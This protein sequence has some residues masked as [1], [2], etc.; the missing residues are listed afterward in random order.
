M[1]K[2][3][4]GPSRCA[5]ISPWCCHV[6]ASQHP[7]LRGALQIHRADW[8]AAN[9]IT[10]QHLKWEKPWDAIRITRS[11]CYDEGEP[12]S[13]PHKGLWAT[14]PAECVKICLFTA[15]IYSLK[16]KEHATYFFQ[17][18]TSDLDHRPGPLQTNIEVVF[19]RVPSNACNLRNGASTTFAPC[20]YDCPPKTPA[21]VGGLHRGDK[22][23]QAFRRLS[24]R[25]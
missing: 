1:A 23:W 2:T 14:E 17:L 16:W 20:K 6:T 4:G 24:Q 15:Y 7:V 19:P 10:E 9:S 5:E 25:P 12:G 11:I 22:M 8:H 18:Q 13:L 21:T 3:H